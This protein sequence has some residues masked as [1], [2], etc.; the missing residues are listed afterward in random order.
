MATS[1][2]ETLAKQLSTDGSFSRQD[3]RAVAAAS[4]AD[5][6][7]SS[8]ERR[9]L[10][11]IAQRHQDTFDAGGSRALR[12]FL[13]SPSNA[14]PTPLEILHTDP[15]QPDTVRDR[16]IE[17]VGQARESIDGAFYQVLDPPIVDALVDAANRGV[18]V[19]LVTDD[20]Y[21][22]AQDSQAAVDLRVKVKAEANDLHID[23][24]RVKLG[25]PGAP[26]QLE[27]L[28]DRLVALEAELPHVPFPSAERIDLSAAR[29]H[30]DAARAGQTPDPAPLSAAQRE[31][32]N[33]L[34]D[35]RVLQRYRPA[36]ERLLAAGVQL[37]DDDSRELSH[38]KYM[39][40]DQEV[41]WAGS[42]NLQGPTSDR[43]PT[44]GL[45]K[46]A[47]NVV[48]VDS[49]ELATR[50]QGDFDQMI[51]GRFHD[52][53][54][55]LTSGQ[56]VNTGGIQVTP[57]FS[58]EDSIP[59][60]LAGKLES[61]AAELARDRAAGVRLEKP[62]VRLAGFT[63]SHRG[64]ERVV[65]ALIALHQQGADVR[66]V[67]DHHTARASY[68]ASHALIAGGVPVEVAHSSVMMHHKFLSAEDGGRGFV[69][70][71]SANFTGPA[72]ESN[73]ESVLLI[74]S[75]D[76][77]RAYEHVFDSLA[78]NLEPKVT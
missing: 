46:S 57:Y 70:T 27:A 74:E 53:K 44:R 38:N 7:V 71:G 77:A 61:Y 48:V 14:L 72:Y 56:P 36:Y 54:E 69:W 3:G 76:V 35:D 28:R 30:L 29:A 13:S 33:E 4:L 67:L 9:V 68:S 60:V 17:L 26:A 39:V 58:P 1:R 23:L 5:R 34:S 73:D 41:V 64:M 18:K 66:L 42:Y 15:F 31:L 11:R 55:P 21:F 32:S 6:K 22:D 37:R 50:F 20:G 16:F 25:T 78:D 8:T 40:L 24:R 19:R 62:I 75:A 49:P 10:D 63:F 52:D 12:E 59:A 43:A 65:D 2:L 51:D 45:P 47:D